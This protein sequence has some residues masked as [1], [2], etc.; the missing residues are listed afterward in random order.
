M[1]IYEVGEHEQLPY[2][3]LEFVAGDSLARKLDGT[4]VGSR[5]AAELIETL[6]RTMYVAH[7]RGIVHRDLKPSNVLLTTEGQPKITDFG[8]AKHQDE[9]SGQTRTGVILGTPNYMAPEQAAGRIKDVRPPAD[10][11]AL[12]AILYELLTGRPPFRGATVHDTLEQVLRQDPVPLRRLQPEVPRDLE[13]I[14][15]KC[16]EKDP[17]RRDPSAQDL[18]DDLHRFHT[19]HPIQARPASRLTRALKWGKRRPVWATLMAGSLVALLV[20]L[21]TWIFF[22]FQIKDALDQRTA[23]LEATQRIVRHNLYLS[24]VQLAYQLWG[25]GEDRRAR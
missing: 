2:I 4:P 16:L 3:S 11:W 5:Q 21:S 12:G 17:A 22:T 14:C 19:D 25:S 20:L 24:D 18:T 8:L 23:E 9:D 10:V 1:Q 15:L 7:Q 13:T 6:A